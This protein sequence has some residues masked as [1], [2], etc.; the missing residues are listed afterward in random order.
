LNVQ[1]LQAGQEAYAWSYL[2]QIPVTPGESYHASVLMLV[3]DID[4]GLYATVT[5]TWFNAQHQRISSRQGTALREKGVGSVALSETAPRGAVYALVSPAVFNSAPA[6]GAARL[7]F[8]EPVF[9]QANG[10]PAVNPN[11]TVQYRYPSAKRGWSDLSG[12]CRFTGTPKYQCQVS[13]SD[14]ANGPVE[15]RI[16]ALDNAGHFGYSKPVSV[17]VVN[18]G[19]AFAQSSY[20]AHE[21]ARTLTVTV[22]R[23]D[24][25]GAEWFYYGL[26]GGSAIPGI[27]VGAVPLTPA[28]MASGQSSYTFK[29]PIIDRG[30][31]GPSV[32]AQLYLA[33]A[34][35]EPVRTPNATVTVLRDDPLQKR[36]RFRPLGLRVIDQ[37]PLRGLRFYIPGS[38]IDLAQAPAQPAMSDNETEA[39][40]QIASRPQTR[41]FA[42]ANGQ[43]VASAVSAY[44]E[45]ASIGQ[46]GSVPLL[47]VRGIT[48][49][50]CAL[51]GSSAAGASAFASWI[52]AFAYGIGNFRAVVFLEPG[53][54]ARTKCASRLVASRVAAEI[55]FETKILEADPH[56]AVYIDG[57]GKGLRGAAWTTG[58]LRRAG[59]ARAQGFFLNAFRYDWVTSE[60]AFGQH[61]SSR[62]QDAHF[63][64]DTSQDGRGPVRRGARCKQDGR[65]LGP[66]STRTG[67]AEADALLWVTGPGI[68][69]G[70]CRGAPHA[71]SFWPA[72]AASLV[73][74]AVRRITGPHHRLRRSRSAFALYGERRR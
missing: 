9:E 13:P 52:K 71:G 33:D 25:L 53:A 39:V 62:L 40:D 30:I 3:A 73:R 63:V 60:L 65:G 37:D 15:L 17:V 35:P 56:V 8:T 12:G 55:R 72:Y 43:D 64:I 54:V 74:H 7:I 28:R 67:Y 1:S 24:G 20:T 10:E 41:I 29:V 14:L 16:A 31:N 68:S 69:D 32:Q 5:V 22:T 58:Y 44:L 19:L 51:R 34:Y 4:P 42:R 18:P 46:P 45:Q 61:L 36:S 23:S 38:Q 2:R 6:T 26:S 57:G 11:V 48:L 50:R 47:A 21:S 27:D 66:I 70:S 59:V 49:G